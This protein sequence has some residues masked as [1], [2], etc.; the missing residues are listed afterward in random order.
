MRRPIPQYKSLLCEWI[1]DE[2]VFILVSLIWIWVRRWPHELGDVTAVVRK[3]G[4]DKTEMFCNDEKTNDV[5]SFRNTRKEWNGEKGIVSR[6]SV[7]LT[8]QAGCEARHLIR[9]AIHSRVDHICVL[10]DETYLRVAVTLLAPV[11]DVGRAHLCGY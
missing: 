9:L 1:C 11:I 7:E 10:D 5:M 8:A 2:A 6:T 3:L 4:L